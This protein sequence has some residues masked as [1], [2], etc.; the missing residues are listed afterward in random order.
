[1]IWRGLVHGRLAKGSVELSAALAV[2]P[3][4]PFFWFKASLRN[5]SFLAAASFAFFARAS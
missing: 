3:V 1:L 2:S 5:F 4:V